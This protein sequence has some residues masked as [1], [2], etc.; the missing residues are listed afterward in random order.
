MK[1]YYKILGVKPS[2]TLPEIKK[3]YRSLAFKYHPDKN[4]DS[5]LAE[6]HFKELQEA[7]AILSVKA[8]REHYD[9]ERWLN[10]MGGRTKYEEAVTPGWLVTICTQLNASLAVMDTH[11]ISQRALQAYILLILDDSNLGVLERYRDRQANG[12]IVTELLK[13]LDKLEVRY[14]HEI[15]QKMLLLAKGN[16]DL[17]LA[18]YHYEREKTRQTR[19]DNLL[20]FVVLIVTLLLCVFMYF[21]GMK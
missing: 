4:P 21:F 10:G 12:T 2:A 13:A 9:D 7:Y 3:A 15:I 17:L 16:N 11:R 1:D 5:L 19:F 20:P 6:A 14:L 18:I 8:R